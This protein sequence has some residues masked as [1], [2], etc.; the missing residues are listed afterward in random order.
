[1]YLLPV[2]LG[3]RYVMVSLCPSQSLKPARRK[4]IPLL[5]GSQKDSS[6]FQMIPRPQL[7]VSVQ[8]PAW[9]LCERSSSTARNSTQKV[10]YC[11]AYALFHKTLKADSPEQDNTLYFGC[12]SATKDQHYAVEWENHAKLDGLKY[13]LAP[14]RDGPDGVRRTYVQHLVEE[15]AEHVWDVVS[16]RNGWVYISG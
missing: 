16:K 6:P 14:S 1:M 4:A 11:D 7:Y 3:P 13:R 10:R 12:R 8:E 15:D 5:S 9:P 2:H